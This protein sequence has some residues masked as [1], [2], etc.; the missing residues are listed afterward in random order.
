MWCWLIHSL[1]SV[2]S[3]QN[4]KIK[5]RNNPKKRDCHCHLDVLSVSF[6]QYLNCPPEGATDL[7]VSCCSLTL[8]SQRFTNQIKMNM[9]QTD[10]NINRF[11]SATLQFSD[12]S[13][14]YWFA[15]KRTLTEIILLHKENFHLL[16]TDIL[17]LY[18]VQNAGLSPAVEYLVFLCFKN[19]GKI[20]MRRRRRR[21]W[22]GGWGW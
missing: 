13:V 7:Y 22:W 6:L 17:L 9:R 19:E 16:N 18:E 15:L 3:V 12:A 20:K 14:S 8:I 5:E 4:N 10:E 11:S 1:S 2:F 21:W